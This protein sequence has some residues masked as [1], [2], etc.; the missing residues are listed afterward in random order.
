MFQEQINEQM[1]NDELYRQMFTMNFSNG[2]VVEKNNWLFYENVRIHLHKVYLK[3]GNM[4]FLNRCLNTISMYFFFRNANSIIHHT[5]LSTLKVYTSWHT[6]IMYKKY[7]T[8]QADTILAS[9][10]NITHV[11]CFTF[12]ASIFAVVD[13]VSATFCNVWE[14]GDI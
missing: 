9:W 8:R 1:F 13:L 4:S 12:L 14:M 11:V 2:M 7:N 5:R 3:G 10:N 6:P